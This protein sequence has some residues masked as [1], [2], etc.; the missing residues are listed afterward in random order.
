[1]ELGRAAYDLQDY[2]L[3]AD[4]FLE[5]S[6][7]YGAPS[8]DLG[9]VEARCEL[10][11]ALFCLHGA[12]RLPPRYSELGNVAGIFGDVW[13]RFAGDMRRANSLTGAT[14]LWIGHLDSLTAGRDARPE[15]WYLYA[16]DRLAKA[17]AEVALAH[18]TALWLSHCADPRIRG[19]WDLYVRLAPRDVP[20][21]SQRADVGGEHP[22]WLENVWLGL[23]ERFSRICGSDSFEALTCRLAANRHFER[24]E[25]GTRRDLLAAAEEMVQRNAMLDRENRLRPYL[26]RKLKGA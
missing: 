12:G 3:A 11:R 13:M 7:S 5:A 16:K 22:Q 23:T 10:A 25:Y 24:Y 2:Q 15:Q 21:A 9:W 8:G 20:G 19:L 26:R 4:C 14:L 1:M 6:E 17:P 18:A